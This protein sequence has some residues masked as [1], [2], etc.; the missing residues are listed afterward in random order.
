MPSTLVL[1]LGL[2]VSALAFP[3]ALAACFHQARRTR[4]GVKSLS[5]SLHRGF[6]AE[7]YPPQRGERILT[8]GNVRQRQSGSQQ[9]N[10]RWPVARLVVNAWEQA[11]RAP[12][13]PPLCTHLGQALHAC[14][15][16]TN[17]ID[18]ATRITHVARNALG[19]RTRLKRDVRCPTQGHTAVARLCGRR[20]WYLA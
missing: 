13:S 3:V 12:A 7:F 19:R 4:Q 5:L 14:A 18:A 17:A 1:V 2:I 8:R 15:A 20:D 16:S 9:L 6:T 10:R 11:S